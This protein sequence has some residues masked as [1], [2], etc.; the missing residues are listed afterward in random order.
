MQ[1]NRLRICTKTYRFLGYGI[2]MKRFLIFLGLFPPLVLLVFLVPGI[3]TSPELPTFRTL[4]GMLGIAY[5]VATVPAWL[6]A[7]MDWYLSQKPT[8]VSITV[9]ATTGFVLSLVSAY[10]LGLRAEV[11]NDPVLIGM[12]GAIPA[13]VCCWLS[14][15]NQVQ[16][17]T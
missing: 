6:L 15:T 11:R 8:S 12:V 14:K 9:T 10:V 2:A 4:Y 5:F 1:E 7:F 17:D 3:V 16:Q 13:V